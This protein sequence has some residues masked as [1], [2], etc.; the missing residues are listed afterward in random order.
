MMNLERM[1]A[2]FESLTPET[3]QHI[4]AFYTADAYFKDPFNEV[5]GTAAISRIFTHM[6][7]QVH[8]PR[9]RVVDRV[10]TEDGAFLTWEFTF[11]FRPAAPVQSVRGASHL[12]FDAAGKVAYHHDYWDAAGELYEK[13]PV[14][15]PVLRLLRRR[16]SAGG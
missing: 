2:Y 5:R 4:G 6:F 8:E 15:G 11:R 10:R 13:L 1:V 12:R 3:A 7:E 16:L 9:F 14:L